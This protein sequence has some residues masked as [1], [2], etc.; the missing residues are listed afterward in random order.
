MSYD[1]ILTKT[2]SIS[3]NCGIKNSLFT[4]SRLGKNLAVR[5]VQKEGG[6]D[7][8]ASTSAAAAAD[9]PAAPSLLETLPP[10]LVAKIALSTQSAKSIAIFACTAK[11]SLQGL[12]D[13]LRRDP[14]SVAQVCRIT[15]SNSGLRVAPGGEMTSW[16]AQALML[17]DDQRPLVTSASTF[18]VWLRSGISPA[19]ALVPQEM[20]PAGAQGGK[21]FEA[22]LDAAANS[23]F[24]CDMIRAV[25]NTVHS[26][27][28]LPRHPSVA[29]VAVEYARRYFPQ[30]VYFPAGEHERRQNFATSYAVNAFHQARTGMLLV[31]DVPAVLDD[32]LLSPDGKVAALC[33]DPCSAL[34]RALKLI[35]NSRRA[36]SEPGAMA[37]KRAVLERL[38][39]DALDS[40]SSA[41]DITQATEQRLRHLLD[42]AL[43]EGSGHGINVALVLSV[44]RASET[45]AAISTDF[46]AELKDAATRGALRAVRPSNKRDAPS[47]YS[48][49]SL[50]MAMVRAGSIDAPTADVVKSA[51]LSHR[52][53]AWKD[54]DATSRQI[55]ERLDGVSPAKKKRRT[56]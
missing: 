48:R 51:L 49:L 32:L 44:A 36:W 24:K 25:L 31:S 8:S 4:L 13:G 17:I 55:A 45:T 15:E 54:V 14:K 2:W 56:G 28:P 1:G 5:L 39:Q 7:V 52:M 42:Y 6:E 20:S 26:H 23:H 3:G 11:S 21:I 47:S 10:E 43:N 29:H 41:G 19:H 22:L 34:K 30:D 16:N 37:F 33:R 46:V 18:T 38:V 53:P 27:T 35:F 40:S 50:A 12:Q 9:T